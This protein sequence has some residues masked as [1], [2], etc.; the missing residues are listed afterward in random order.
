M[1]VVLIAVV[2][3]ALAAM[4]AGWKWGAS[5]VGHAQGQ[6]TVVGTSSVD[7]AQDPYTTD[8]WSWGDD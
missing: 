3:A 2:V 1:R 4:A 7:D 6:Y 5:P 8:G